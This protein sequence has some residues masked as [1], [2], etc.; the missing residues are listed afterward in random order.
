MRRKHHA[1]ASSQRATEPMKDASVATAESATEHEQSVP[2]EPARESASMAP[3]HESAETS[4]GDGIDPNPVVELLQSQ[5]NEKEHLVAALTDRLEQAAEQLDRLRRTGADK[6][7]RSLAGGGASLPADLIQDHKSTLEEL[8]RVIG[9]WEDIQ[10]GA[11]LGRIETQVVE[12]RDLIAGSLQKG[13][14]G[15]LATSTPRD[16]K[17]P[18]TPAAPGAK[19]SPDSWWERQKAALLGEAPAEENNAPAAESPA[20]PAEAPAEETETPREPRSTFSWS[21]TTI[22]DLPPEIDFENITLEEAREAL[23]LRDQVIQQLREPLL[24]LRAAGELPRDLK[25]LDD[26]PE[27]LRQRI[28]TLEAQWQAKF[29]QGELDLSLERAR[30][31]REQ[32]QVRQQQELFQKQLKQK[33]NFKDQPVEGDKEDTASR[34]RWFRFMGKNGEGEAEPEASENP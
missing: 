21:D 19:A 10:A 34:R 9:N 28:E 32:S 30:L 33:G 7:R 20:A 1:P 11:T 23:R 2:H 31:A 13:T 18:T 14:L 27:A 8:K 16:R 15:G 3:A 29:R 25:S 5:L 26:L 12:L 24:L 4:R 6:G 17:G 22:P